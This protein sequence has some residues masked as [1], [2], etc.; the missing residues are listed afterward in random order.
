[1]QNKLEDSIHIYLSG[2]MSEEEKQKFELEILSSSQLSE[3]VD[4]Y[5]K[6]WHL[7]NQLSYDQ[8]ASETEVSWLNFEKEVKAP[9]RTLTFNW[10]KIAASVTLL[11]AL[12]VS[13]WFFG[14]TNI[15]FASGTK[16]GQLQ[17]VDNTSITLDKYSTLLYSKNFGKSNREVTLNGQGYFDVAKDEMP[18]VV[19][20]SNGDIQV[21]GTQFNVLSSDDEDFMLIE[22]VEG[23]IEYTNT[24]ERVILKP[25]D[26]L[27][28]LD[29]QVDISTFAQV[30]TWGDNKINCS[31]V[32]MAYI[33]NQ[34]EL[35]YNVSYK[36]TNKLL[37]EHYTVSLPKDNLSECIRI[38]NDVSGKSF[39][40][41]DGVIALQ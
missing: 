25:G 17:L 12:S 40:L 22:L 30:S 1:M 10:L 35:V 3:S 18:F 33:L 27:T 37:K 4:A 31:D 19:H 15:S 21:L 41:I 9:K 29:G 20:T 14:S 36:A 39:A 26:R 24:T 6:I 5:K 28:L 13:M 2:N 38:L 32:P 7:T 16:V 8:D 34:L 23:S 11:V